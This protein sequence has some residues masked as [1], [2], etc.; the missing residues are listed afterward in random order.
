VL[1]EAVYDFMTA[2]E[3]G[4]HEDVLRAFFRLKIADI[5]ALL[6]RVVAIAKKASQDTRQNTAKVLP[7]ANQIV[8]VSL[9]FYLQ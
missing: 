1:D 4:Y 5:G 7:E 3:E 6:V 9:L 2:A 8:Y